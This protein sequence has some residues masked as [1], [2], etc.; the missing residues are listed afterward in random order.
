[1]R[2]VVKRMSNV[3]IARSTTSAIESEGNAAVVAEEEGIAGEVVEEK[4]GTEIT[5]EDLIAE[6]L[7][8]RDHPADATREIEGHSAHLYRESQIHMFLVAAE[9]ADEMSAEDHLHQSQYLLRPSGQ[10]LSHVHHLDVGFGQPRDLAHR[11]HEDVDP[12]RRIDVPL[13]T[14]EEEAE[15]EGEV[16]IVELVED[17]RLLRP[18]VLALRDHRN[19]E[20]LPHPHL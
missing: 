2:A 17:H 20:D 3:G 8:I 16:R 13:H 5:A 15:A 1:M 10:N 7:D 19:E 14:E 6:D 11:H 4:T 18:P 12:G 9:A